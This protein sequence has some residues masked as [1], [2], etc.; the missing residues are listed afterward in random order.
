MVRSFY[1]FNVYFT[2]WRILFELGGTNRKMALP[3][4]PAF[5]QVDNPFVVNAYRKL[6]TEFGIDSSRDFRYTRG[7]N[8]GLGS[9]YTDDGKTSESYP[10]G[11]QKFP[12][13]VEGYAKTHKANFSLLEAY[14][15][16]IKYI[17]NNDAA[18]AQPDWFCLN[19]SEGLTQTGLPRI[20]QSIKA[21]LYCILSAQVDLR[22]SILG[23]GSRTKE[24]QTQFLALFE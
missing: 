10:D 8:N 15:D 19:K 2:I 13:D 17:E 24:T 23:T 20:N 22:S 7:D 3:G 16:K 12:D 6:C 4:D 21:F 14:L 9:V 18:D 11:H 1:L 5:N